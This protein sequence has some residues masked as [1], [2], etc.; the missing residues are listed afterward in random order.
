[1]SFGKILDT[2]TEH[3]DSV[4]FED[5][6]RAIEQD[7]DAA[8][9]NLYMQAR[10]PDLVYEHVRALSTHASR[11]IQGTRNVEH[12]AL[13]LM[14]VVTRTGSAATSLGTQIDAMSPA[15]L[16]GRWLQDW[17]LMQTQARCYAY[18]PCYSAIASMSPRQV[19]NALGGLTQRNRSVLTVFLGPSAEEQAQVQAGLP[20][21]A[22]MVGS[23][24]C[25][26]F[27]PII[28]A[29]GRSTDLELFQ[30]VISV[31]SMCSI[32]PMY[33]GEHHRVAVPAPFSEAL[34]TGLQMW[35]QEVANHYETLAWD[36]F[37]NGAGNV[38]L[39]WVVSDRDTG[40]QCNIHR[41]LHAAQLGV[42]NIQ[43]VLCSVDETGGVRNGIRCLAA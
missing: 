16:I 20:D 40:M 42:K 23:V 6:A 43:A 15:G 25:F 22:F 35:V 10:R 29:A 24:S 9:E 5:V 27:D 14:P 26:G 8:L 17:F 12:S 4:L 28:P 2:S 19:R 38:M 11:H 41:R 36:A 7:D 34:C 39:R 31:L 18:L 33:E 21:L 3:S 1:M 13:W 30:R 32:D 37:P